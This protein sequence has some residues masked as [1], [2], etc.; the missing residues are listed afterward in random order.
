MKVIIIGGVA[1]GA[2]AASRIRRLNETAQ[3]TI[4]EKS[5]YISYANCG[6]PYYLGGVIK[7]K[8]ALI[9]QTPYS[10]LKRYN[11]DVFVSHEVIKVDTK[12]KKVYVKNLLTNDI[13][14]DEYDKLLIAPGS[15]AI[16]PPIEGI[17]SNKIFYLKNVE[18]TYK[19]EDYIKNNR[20]KEVTVVG[21]GF[22]GVEA[23]E[24]FI[25]KGLKVNLVEKANQVLTFLDEDMASFA[26]FKLKQ[27]GINL[28][29]GDGVK[30]FSEKGAKIT[31]HT[32]KGCK[33]ESDLIILSLGVRPATDFLKDSGIKLNARGYIKVD[34][35]LKTNIDDVYAVGDAVIIINSKTNKITTIPLA[36]PANKQARIAAD[37]IVGKRVSE[38]KGSNSTSIVKVFDFAF[39][40]TGINERA[41]KAEGIN[42]EK[43]IISASSHAS[44]YP[45]AKSLVLKVIFDKDSL[46]ILGGQILGADGVDK[47]I[48]SLSTLIYKDG[49]ILD[50]VDIDFAYA[51]P[52]GSAKDPLNMVGYVA[53]NLINGTLKQFDN[54]DIDE[55]IAN[56]I[57]YNL[58]DLRTPNEF[59]LGSI[60]HFKNIPLDELRDRLSEIDF[61]KPIYVICQS[62]LRSYLGSRILREYSE[63]VYN[64][65]GG[66]SY[67]SFTNLL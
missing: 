12:E 46:K 65:I 15:S 24:N 28:I 38:Y 4:Y 8:N 37:N 57:K 45:G 53:D 48:D 16:K 40:S 63:D 29:L 64:Y 60:P 21:G 58:I 2:T 66:Y 67:Y 23:A 47:R 11:I 1:G 43:V 62:G 17:E 13:F 3:I 55:L 33:I 34:E 39:A 44:Y 49:S 59:M 30:S 9:L 35:N 18:D 41:A 14:F 26:H 54:S 19:I 61:T 50:L 42:Y 56:H 25:H 6:L 52:F 36:G 27:N 32:E 5:G 31:L 20:V 7:D 51:P 10:F 22:I